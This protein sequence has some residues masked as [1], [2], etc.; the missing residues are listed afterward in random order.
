MSR[1]R[2]LAERLVSL[3][4]ARL[5]PMAHWRFIKFGVVGASG[6]VINIAVLYAAQEHLLQGIADFHVRLNY[7]IALAIT[8]AT[9]SNFYWNRRLTWRDRGRNIPQS[10][11]LLFSKYVMAAAL[12][13]VVQS[14]LTKWLA[15]YWHYI[16]ANLMAIAVASVVN[17][18]ANDRLTFRRHRKKSPP[19]SAAD[20]KAIPSEHRHDQP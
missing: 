13:I 18:V 8:V 12:S 16:V 15:V 1:L 4:P 7:S 10:A 11:L 6:T 19:P 3:L 20:A 9:I 2:S 14:L 17:F 5:Q